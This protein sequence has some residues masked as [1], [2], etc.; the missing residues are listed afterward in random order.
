MNVVDDS[1]SPLTYNG[2]EATDS[3][4]F[5]S[6]NMEMHRPISTVVTLSSPVQEKH[7]LVEVQDRKVVYLNTSTDE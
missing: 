3:P 4:I 1:Q 6:P 7:K 5:F 2:V